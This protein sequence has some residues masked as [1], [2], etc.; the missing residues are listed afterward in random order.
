MLTRNTDLP[1]LDP[2]GPTGANFQTKTMTAEQLHRSADRLQPEFARNPTQRFLMA[3]GLYA[4]W[5]GLAWLSELLGQ[6]RLPAE[7][8][9]LLL[10]G[11]AATN[12]LFFALARAPQ[13]HQPPPA[14]M[15]AVQCAV[16]LGWASVFTW[17]GAGGAPLTL[18]MY[19]TTILFALFQVGQRTFVRLALLASLAYAGIVLAKGLQSQADAAYWA[20]ALNL[21]I[22]LGTVAWLLVFG[23]HLHEL[24]RQLHLRNAELQDMVQKVSRVAERDHLTKSFNR[25]YIMETL[26][27]EKG[28][29][30]RSNN[31]VSVCIFDLDHF[32]SI[33]DHFGHLVG[34]RILKGF[35]RRVRAELRTMDAVNPSDYRRSFGRFGGE[36]FIVILPCTSLT[37]AERCAE[38]IR[39]AIAARP[40]DDVYRVTV[41]A[42][43]AE[44]R[45]G[46]TVPELLARADEALYRAKAEGRDRVV[47]SGQPVARAAT[48]LDLRRAQP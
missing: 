25:H 31:P 10:A 36:E 2:A 9:T 35:A 41:S 6:L 17:F 24:R 38:R 40:F 32:K 29:A 15:V 45:R 30:D 37:G 16:G 5:T 42:G 11:L 3:F 27:R 34:D 23:H 14:A 20:H 44:Y 13:G 33:N 39:K 48:I 28:R 46:E 21:A 8:E 12:V 7:A 18:G 43:V 4:L 19:L 1:L 22:F 26:A 47:T